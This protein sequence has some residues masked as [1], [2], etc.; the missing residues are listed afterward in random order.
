VDRSTNQVV[1]RSPY[2][3]PHTPTRPHL[4]F[5][6]LFRV[7][8]SLQAVTRPRMARIIRLFTL[9]EPTHI[10][11]TLV[12]LPCVSSSIPYH[13][14]LLRSPALHGLARAPFPYKA[15]AVA[16]HSIVYSPLSLT[17]ISDGSLA[18]LFIVPAY[19]HRLFPYWAT[20]RPTASLPL[21]N[22]SPRPPAT[23]SY[24]HPSFG[25]NRCFQMRRT[26][27]SAFG[28]SLVSLTRFR[29]HQTRSMIQPVRS[30]IV[31]YGGLILAG[32]RPQPDGWR[33]SSC[34]GSNCKSLY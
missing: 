7:N 26:G 2:S 20:L 13:Q 14:G 4:Y 31:R 1:F 21:F 30:V 3:T 32:R 22:L 9:H 27:R 12:V 6:S 19:S 24:S 33:H 25:S 34:Q 11:Y 17:A 18:T 8:T 23:H 28:Y 5:G 29:T 16:G 10:R 15:S